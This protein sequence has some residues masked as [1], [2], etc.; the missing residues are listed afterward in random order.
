MNNY[1]YCLSRDCIHKRGCKRNIENYKYVYQG[2]IVYDIQEENKSFINEKKCKNNSFKSLD[3]F[4]TSNIMEFAN[5][6]YD[7]E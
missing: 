5:L 6:D 7:N 4:R 2:F 3:R 1:K